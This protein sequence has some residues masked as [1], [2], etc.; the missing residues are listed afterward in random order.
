MARP[1]IRWRSSTSGSSSRWPSSCGASSR[2]RRNSAIWRISSTSIPCTAAR[3]AS[4]VLSWPSSGCGKFPVGAIV[5]RAFPIP[6][7]C[8]IL[9]SP[10]VRFRSVHWKSVPPETHR[11]FSPRSLRGVAAATNS[12]RASPAKRATRP[13]HSCANPSSARR[14]RRT[15]GSSPR[16]RARDSSTTGAV[17]IF[18]GQSAILPGRK[19]ATKKHS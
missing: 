3:T 10:A 1:S 12:T 6:R 5:S 4:R 2:W 17:R 13:F 19:R 15:C 7:P 18:S 16:P 14:R 8:G 11:R 9:F